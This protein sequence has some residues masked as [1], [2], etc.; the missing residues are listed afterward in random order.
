MVLPFQAKFF[1][2]LSHHPET[3]SRVTLAL[4]GS[5]FQ[6]KRDEKISHNHM[7]ELHFYKIYLDNTL[8]QI[9]FAQNNY[10]NRNKLS[11]C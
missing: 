5:V 8:E 4:L 3:S 6:T 7:S 2:S 9:N 10:G 11:N 1:V